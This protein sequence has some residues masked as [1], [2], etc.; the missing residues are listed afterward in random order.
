MNKSGET[1]EIWKIKWEAFCTSTIWSLRLKLREM[2]CL[3]IIQ[4]LFYLQKNSYF[5][6]FDLL[7]FKIVFTCTKINENSS[8]NSLYSL[9]IFLC[10]EWYFTVRWHHMLGW[11]ITPYYCGEANLNV[12]ILFGLRF[13]DD[14]AAFDR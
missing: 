12:N 8:N 1:N 9:Q 10:F 7:K 13:Y 3:K 5:I 6:I 4:N 14:V 11:S 2:V